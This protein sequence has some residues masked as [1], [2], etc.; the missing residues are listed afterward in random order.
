MGERRLFVV[1]SLSEEQEKMLQGGG[2]STTRRRTHPANFKGDPTTT[3][4]GAYGT[5]EKPTATARK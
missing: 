1:G 5:R 3:G 2:R 4:S